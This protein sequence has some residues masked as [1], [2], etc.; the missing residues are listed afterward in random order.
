M[1]TQATQNAAV[2]S[3]TGAFQI[4]APAPPPGGDIHEVYESAAWI[5][6]GGYNC[7]SESAL[8]RT[9]VTF[10]YA[11]GD[12]N[13]NAWYEW[14]PSV[15]RTYYDINVSIGDL[16]TASVTAYTSRSGTVTL[17]N[18]STG[19]QTSVTL[20][21]AEYA[22]LC[23]NSVEYIVGDTPQPNGGEPSFP[24]P[25]FGTLAFSDAFVSITPSASPLTNL[26]NIEQGEA[27]LTSVST[28]YDT[29]TIKYIGDSE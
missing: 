7:D 3:V 22:T 6:I 8:L 1:L 11:N 10:I 27:A 16:I 26:L 20:G 28:E 13:A 2:H 4:P 23:M 18:N 9:G 25:A 21:S 15:D 12:V 5:G 17:I 14:Y 19:A 24:F 29:I